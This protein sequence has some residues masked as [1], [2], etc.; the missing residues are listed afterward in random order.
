MHRLEGG[1]EG[2]R[3]G[4]EHQ[5]RAEGGFVQVEKVL[6]SFLGGGDVVGLHESRETFTAVVGGCL[7][8]VSEGGGGGLREDMR[9]GGFQRLL[10]GWVV[11]GDMV[12]GSRGSDGG[13]LAEFVEGVVEV[14]AEVGLLLETALDG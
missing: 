3:A 12:E 2:V 11:R 9:V 8:R 1:E 6:Q 5:S 10:G 7:G 13:C 4:F 14:E